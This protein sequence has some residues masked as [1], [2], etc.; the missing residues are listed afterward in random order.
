MG[1]GDHGPFQGWPYD[2][3]HD[4]L[5][6]EVTKYFKSSEMMKL[7]PADGTVDGGIATMLSDIACTMRHRPLS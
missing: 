3:K 2:Q 5:Y 4:E 7:I 1:I 6:N